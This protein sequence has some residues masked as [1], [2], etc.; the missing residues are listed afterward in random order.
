MRSLIPSFPSVPSLFSRR[1]PFD[2][3]DELERFFEPSFRTWNQD[4]FTI[5]PACDVEETDDKYILS[6]DVPGV[7]KQDLK[8]EIDGNKLLISGERKRA[9]NGMEEGT[10]RSERSY[11][12]F[13]RMLTLPSSGNTEEVQAHYDNGVLQVV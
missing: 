4:L 1:S 12:R 2:V 13:E 3:F 5:Q 8:L 9:F 6:F 11:G 10:R 7:K